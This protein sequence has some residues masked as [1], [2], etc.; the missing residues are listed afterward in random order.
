MISSSQRSRVQSPHVPVLL[1]QVLSAFASLDEGYFVDCTLGY[2]GHSRA[3]LEAHP[4]L[5]LIGIDRDDEALGFSSEYLEPYRGRTILCKGTFAERLGGLTQTPLVGILA[6][7]GVSSLQLDK[8]ERGFGFESQILDMRMDRTAALS[9]YEV[10]NDYPYEAL[11]RIFREYGEIARA[12]LLAQSVIHA[13]S[14]SPIRSARQLSGIIADTF[15]SRG[16]IHPATLAFQAIRIEVNHELRQIEG[17]LDVLE[18]KRP[19]G[20]IVGLISFHSL[21]DRLVKQRF[22]RWATNCICPPGSIRCTCGNNHALG[23][24]PRRKPLV[25]TPRELRA[26]PR[27]R[28]AKLRLFQ[29]GPPAKSHER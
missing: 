26:N 1:D 7:F 8:D 20:A 4:R 17:L 22:R 21:E 16:K 19:A 14:S 3:I 27:S 5:H 9:A 18:S 13:R 23:T 11:E 29:F 24:L 28:S 6:D 12:D 2:A 10:V 15:A 25:A